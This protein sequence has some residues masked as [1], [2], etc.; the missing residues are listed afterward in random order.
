MTDWLASGEA[1]AGF[2]IDD[3]LELRATT[4]G[5]SAIRYVKHALEGEE[6]RQHIANGKLA[7]RLA[8]TWSDKVSFVLTDKLQIKRLGFLDILKE[9]A[10]QSAQ[11]ADEQFD[12]D[13]AL[14]AGELNQ[15]FGDLLIALGGEMTPA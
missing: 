2:S 11:E 3:Q 12:I 4:A 14:M 6:I 9:E 15:M 8:L 1:P 13:F 10:E 5:Q 7:T